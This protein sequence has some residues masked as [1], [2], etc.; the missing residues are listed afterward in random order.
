MDVSVKREKH[1]RC[2]KKTRTFWGY[3]SQGE[4]YFK[5]FRGQLCFMGDES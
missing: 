4:E 3:G 2:K 1:K 5:E